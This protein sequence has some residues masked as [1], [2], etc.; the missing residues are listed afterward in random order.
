MATEAENRVLDDGELADALID[1]PGW[2]LKGKP[3]A[4]T[5]EFTSFPLAIEFVNQI[6]E[7]A[8]K[9]NHHPDMQINFRKVKVLCWTH[10]FNAVT[11]ADINLAKEVEHLFEKH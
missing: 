1:L 5:Y 3:I 4:K 6:A 8:E 9:H 11:Q 10:K 2:E 7:L